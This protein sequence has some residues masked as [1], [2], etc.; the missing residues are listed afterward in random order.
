MRICSLVGIGLLC[1]WEWVRVC[2][3]EREGGNIPMWIGEGLFFVFMM[4][5]ANS[6][7]L[8]YLLLNCCQGFWYIEAF[9]LSRAHLDIFFEQTEKPVNYKTKRPTSRRERTCPCCSVHVPD[10]TTEESHLELEIR[11]PAFRITMRPHE[12]KMIT[13]QRAAACLGRKVIGAEALQNL[14]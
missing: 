12:N 2:E 8:Q 4:A 6:A 14:D 3:R 10:S 7:L 9:P 13:R 11:I 1:V 5:I